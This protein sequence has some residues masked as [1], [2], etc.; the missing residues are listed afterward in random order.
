MLGP[1]RLKLSTRLSRLWRNTCKLSSQRALQLVTANG[2][3]NTTK[4]P[5]KTWEIEAVMA[6]G[7]VHLQ[8]HG[9]LGNGGNS[10]K[11]NLITVGSQSRISHIS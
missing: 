2:S 4:V 11:E 9:D 7:A 6:N 10:S 3:K 5:Q 8:A 1:I